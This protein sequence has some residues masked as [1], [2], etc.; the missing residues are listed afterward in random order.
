MN[1]TDLIPEIARQF[2]GRRIALC[3]TKEPYLSLAAE[4]VT[5]LGGVVVLMVDGFQPMASYIN[6]VKESQADLV[7][8]G[9]GMPK[10]EDVSMLLAEHADNPLVIV[11]GGAILD[12]WANRFPRAPKVWQTLRLE[13]LFRLLLEPRRLWKRYILGNV[14]FLA[15]TVQLRLSGQF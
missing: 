5:A 6:A 2:L 3:G 13:W 12:F 4:K 7:I 9:M 8:L 11:N 1:G 14:I 15:R 10:Q